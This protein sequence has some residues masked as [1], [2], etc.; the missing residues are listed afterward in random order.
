MYLIRMKVV[1]II[2]IEITK[3]QAKYLRDNGVVQGISRTM[4]QKSK[5]KHI[6]VCEESHV[7]DLLEQYNKALN[8]S[9]TYGSVN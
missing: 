4:R 7:L 3:A 9:F 8:I 2:M 5:R 6:W 1:K